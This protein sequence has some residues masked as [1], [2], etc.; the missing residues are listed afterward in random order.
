MVRQKKPASKRWAFSFQWVKI[1]YRFVNLVSRENRSFP[2]CMIGICLLLLLI[3][4]P[5]QFMGCATTSENKVPEQIA[6]SEPMSIEEKW[7]I[8]I[9]GIRLTAADQML[10]FRYR[11]IDPEK[12]SS[13]LQRQKESYL[14]DQATGRKLAVPKTK[15]GPLRQTSVKPL[16]NRIYFILFANPNRSVKLGTKVTLVLGDL[17]I[18][19]LVVE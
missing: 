10:D 7:G 14:I 11:V 4:S 18:E 17:K 3:V 19:D 8:E 6:K 2:D 15:L 9:I 5:V 1:I 12:A 16:P 13:L